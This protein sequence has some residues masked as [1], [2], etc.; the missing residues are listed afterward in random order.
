MVQLYFPRSA[1][2]LLI[3][4]GSLNCGSS[5][6]GVVPGYSSVKK[7]L[8]GSRVALLCR[9]IRVHLCRPI[10]GT[11]LLVYYCVYL[12]LYIPHIRTNRPNYHAL[13]NQLDIQHI[14]GSDSSSMYWF[15]SGTSHVHLMIR[16]LFQAYYRSSKHQPLRRY[17]APYRVPQAVLYNQT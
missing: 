17:R 1:I 6:S 5:G 4:A 8:S 14:Q 12:P 15:P 7:W 10:R 11:P 16:D 3:L 13:V 9:P 2:S